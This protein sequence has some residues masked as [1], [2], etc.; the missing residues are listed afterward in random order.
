MKSLYQKRSPH[1]YVFTITT[2]LFLV[3]AH[4]AMARS[5]APAVVKADEVVSLETSLVQTKV[6]KGSD[7]KVSMDITLIASDLPPDNRTITQPVD[8]IIVLDRSGSM[9]GQKINDARTAMLRLM[10]HL[11]GADRLGIVSY[12]N[13]VVVHSPLVPMNYPN[14]SR[15]RRL[16]ANIGAGGGTN[17]GSGLHTGVGMFTSSPDYGRQRKLILISDGLA[18]Q[19][20]TDPRQLGTMA[21]NGPEYNFTVSSV[22]VGYDFNEQLMTTIADY[23]GGSYYFLEDPGRFAWIFQ[24]EFDSAR[25]VAASSLEIR[26]QLMDG[27]RLL[28]G[29]GYPIKMEGNVAIIRPGDLL[30]GQKRSFFLTYQVPTSNEQQF[31]LGDIQVRYNHQGSAKQRD[32]AL[33][34]SISCVTDRAEVVGSYDKEAW[35]KQVV[36]E[37]YNQMRSKVAEAVKAGR[38]QEALKSITEFE[39]RNRSLNRQVQSSTVSENLDNDLQQLKES[40]ED[41]FVGAPAAVLQ[42][43]KQQSK[44]LQYESYK[45]RRD[46]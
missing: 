31:Q 22:G 13:N 36:K 26:I 35:G 4:K 34:Y 25:R 43:Q 46:K 29:G 38:K 21:S 42:K 41:T 7:G 18:N 5:F 3:V 23:G 40:V 16:V 14:V 45:I 6:L 27:V 20:V 2:L 8:L 37:D 17:L 30:A 12:A 10:D 15:L 32:H 19:G 28:S 39:Q 24:E 9:N 11:T 44:A 1:L 33:N